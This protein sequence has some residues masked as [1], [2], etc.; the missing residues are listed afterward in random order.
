LLSIAVWF[1]LFQGG[2]TGKW[3]IAAVSF[4]I[5]LITEEVIQVIIV[6]VRKTLVGIKED[7]TK[8]KE[9]AKIRVMKTV[10]AD[11]SSGVSVYTDI[12]ASF[13]VP[14][15]KETVLNGFKLFVESDIGKSPIPGEA[16]Q[17]ENSLTY[18]F[19]PESRKLDPDKTYVASID[20][21]VDLVGRA[22]EITTW[23]FSTR[24]KPMILKVYPEDKQKVPVSSKITIEFSEP[25]NS[26]GIDKYIIVKEK[27]T[28]IKGKVD[29]KGKTATFTPDEKLEID[30]TYSVEVTNEIED[31]AGNSLISGKTWTF[32]TNK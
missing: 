17:D 12:L 6:L 24:N 19:V 14:V 5:G 29:V 11:G 22:C 15:E 9:D 13:E 32:S 3:A 2:T 30:K 31:L 8:E 23:L 25:M 7:T 16:I 1:I 18:R 28:D 27:D 21:V 4:S 20:G 26:Q 10:P